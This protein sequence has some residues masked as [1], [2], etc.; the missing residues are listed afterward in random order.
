MM[1]SALIIPFSATID[2]IT[3]SSTGSQLVKLNAR[4]TNQA[5]VDASGP[6][7]DSIKGLQGGA[8]PNLDLS[9][10]NLG[11]ADLQFLGAVFTSFSKFIAAIRLLN[12]SA[13]KCFG[14]KFGRHATPGQSE[15]TEDGWTTICDALK[16]T[17][18]ETLDI[19]DIGL[20]PSGLT[21]FSNAMSAIATLSTLNLRDNE[22]IEAA[23]IEAIKI[24]APN[25]SIR[26]VSIEH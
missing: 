7:T 10:M 25:V 11:P 26:L 3:L 6:R 2:E 1:I 9:A 4:K 19:S 8:G 20:T 24:L 22:T 21:K 5:I 15:Y 23:D 12:L 16:G 13:N 17:Q 14:M 18:I